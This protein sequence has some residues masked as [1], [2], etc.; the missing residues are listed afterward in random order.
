MPRW[1]LLLLVVG[2]LAFHRVAP[3]RAAGPASF[4][5]SAPLSCPSREAV[6]QRVGQGNGP[7]G[8]IETRVSVE[9][10]GEQHYRARLE[11][12]V[13]HEWSERTLE[14]SSCDAIA[15][16]VVV[17][18]RVA[19]AGAPPTT[20]SAPTP[21]P[22]P[23]AVAAAPPP[24]P[25]PPA[26]ENP[27][28]EESAGRGF[29]ARAAFAIDVGTASEATPG[30]RLGAAWRG[31]H[32][33]FAVDVGAF[34]APPNR[35]SAGSMSASPIPV[36][37]IATDPNGTLVLG[38]PAGIA[39]PNV[40]LLM[41]TAEGCASEPLRHDRFLVDACLGVAL[42]H[43]RFSYSVGGSGLV[44]LAEMA[45]EWWPLHALGVRGS[46]RVLLD[47]PRS[48]SSVVS[49][50]PSIGIATHLGP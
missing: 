18:V 9:Q 24:S 25:R 34:A 17:I 46:A 29:S 19:V 20:A 28:L 11:L 50:E 38:S 44:P 27:R 49:F 48:S 43:P 33:A 14:A 36:S 13:D 3:A 45:A 47:V 4:E 32:L 30:F 5:W 8:P 16:A 6:L 2:A 22:P 39:L 10:D 12:V 37:A 31:S 21:S 35:A 7:P 26:L 40:P 1:T 42:E 41:A 15:D 23:P